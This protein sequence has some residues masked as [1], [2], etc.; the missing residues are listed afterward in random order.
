MGDP[1][2]GT[3]QEAEATDRTGARFHLCPSSVCF[4]RTVSYLGAS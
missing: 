3:H 1:G 4:H 2:M